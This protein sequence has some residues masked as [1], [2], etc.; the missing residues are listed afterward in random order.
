MLFRALSGPT[1]DAPASSD[2]FVACF[3]T[4][5]LRFMLGRLEQPEERLRHRAR[6]HAL[7]AEQLL[8]LR[9]FW[10]RSH[11]N[12]SHW[13]SRIERRSYV[14]RGATPEVTAAY[15]AWAL[16]EL[17]TPGLEVEFA[18]QAAAA[19]STSHRVLDDPMRRW[20]SVSGSEQAASVLRAAGVR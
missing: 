19:K 17:A 12:S 1:A 9:A 3:A 11:T 7:S 5:W 4:R 15:V 13:I 10:G 14:T 6:R 20:S 18:A 16:N 2:E 8:Q